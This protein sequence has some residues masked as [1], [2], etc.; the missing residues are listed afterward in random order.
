[1]VNTDALYT[2]QF[3]IPPLNHLWVSNCSSGVSKFLY[4][5]RLVHDCFKVVR[6][7]VLERAVVTMHSGACETGSP[8]PRPLGREIGRTVHTSPSTL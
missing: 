7:I 4:H 1:M 2:I 3:T 6:I 8:I 5:T